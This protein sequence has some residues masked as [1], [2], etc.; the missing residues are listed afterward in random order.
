VDWRAIAA[1]HWTGSSPPGRACGPLTVDP[2]ACPA[3]GGVDEL[4]PL[5][6]TPCRRCV[7]VTALPQLPDVDL[8]GAG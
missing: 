2:H 1:E 5:P 7:D 8:G 3:C 4:N 6:G